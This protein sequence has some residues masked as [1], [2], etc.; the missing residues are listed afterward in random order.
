MIL[1]RLI[2]ARKSSLTLWTPSQISTSIWID[3]SDASTVTLAGSSVSQINDKSGNGNNFLQATSS[4]QPTY[5]IASKNSLNTMRFTATSAQLL[6]NTTFIYASDKLHSF[7]VVKR[8]V[9]SSS[10]QYGRYLTFTNTTNAD[11]F[12]NANSL[13]F[14]NNGYTTFS[15]FRLSASI[16]A[17]SIS[18]N[19]WYLFDGQRNGTSGQLAKN[20]GTYATGATNSANQNINVS[21]IGSSYFSSYQ[22]PGSHDGE[23]AEIVVLNYI[24]S[25][26]NINKLQGY[27]AWKWGMES[28]LPVGHPYKNAPPYV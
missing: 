1:L 5:L 24:P 20:A 9:D 25:S 13:I 8:G 7:M 11:D 19:T 4:K 2:T 18:Q 17:Q 26:T 23:I 22:G 28:D 3:A 16:A 14:T 12:A 21:T 27:L 6:I 10:S 15:L